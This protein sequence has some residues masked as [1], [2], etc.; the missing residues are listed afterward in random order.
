MVRITLTAATTAPITRQRH[1]HPPE[2]ATGI[3]ITAGNPQA[4]VPQPR[5]SE[6]TTT[7]RPKRPNLQPPGESQRHGNERVTTADERPCHTSTRGER[8]RGQEPRCPSSDAYQRSPGAHQEP[9]Q[10]PRESG[11]GGQSFK[12]LMAAKK[13]DA[14]ITGGAIP[15]YNQNP[16]CIW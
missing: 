1:P 7:R 3:P 13:N 6:P 12:I 2:A 10:A 15:S 16:K 9:S 11:P 5:G 14:A 4:A 8:E